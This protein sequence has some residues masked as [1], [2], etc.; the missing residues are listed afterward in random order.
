[1]GSALN[2]R[3]VEKRESISSSLRAIRSAISKLLTSRQQSA[4]N[5]KELDC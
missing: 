4:Y 1:M 5:M 3:R 2:A